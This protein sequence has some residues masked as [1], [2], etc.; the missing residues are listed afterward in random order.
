MQAES[1]AFADCFWTEDA[2]EGVIAFVEKRS[3]KFTGR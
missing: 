3:A 1:D 2:R